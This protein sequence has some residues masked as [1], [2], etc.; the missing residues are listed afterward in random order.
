MQLKQKNNLAIA[1]ASLMAASSISSV[2]AADWSHEA[3]VLYYGESDSRVKDGSVKYNGVR[4]SEGDK[5]LTL[6]LGIDTLTGAS[7]SGVAPSN[8]VQTLTS[9]SGNSTI[10]HP[11][12][13]LP[14]DDSF[15]DTRVSAAISWDQPILDDNT[16]TNVGASFSKEYD[17][18]HLGVSSGVSREFNNKNTTFSVGFAFSADTVDPVG[19]API[20]LSNQDAAKGSASKSKNTLETMFGVT[21]ILSPKTIAQLNYGFSAAEGYLN[22]PYK[23]VSRVDNTGKIVESLHEARPDARTGHNVYGAIK[24]TLSGSNVLTTSARLHTD[25][26]GIDSYTLD[27]R[28][29][30]GLGSRK[31]IEPHIRYYHQSA[32]DFYTP[33]LNSTAALPENASADY[34]LAEF[35]AYTLGAT[36]RWGGK[37]DREW[38]VTGEF[39]TQ[40]PT[41]VA[42]T[43]GQ[44]GLDANPGFDAFMLSLGVKF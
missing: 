14:L 43:A 37:N 28:Y 15:H 40:K 16:R 30:V 20:P 36:Y 11:A 5:K 8:T 44:T 39:Y 27:A 7:P 26:W 10:T 32:A 29:Q 13:E 23:W 41:R 34:R 4:T 25:D 35:D 21:Q 38:R 2:S 12:G 42:L 22:D 33:Q 1:A 19:H 9:P 6:N 3:S 17:Y 31:S 18:L 24:H